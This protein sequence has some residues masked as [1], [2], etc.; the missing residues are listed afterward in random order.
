MNREFLE[1]LG[2]QK[3]QVDQIMAEHGK[4]VQTTQTKLTAS[5]DRVKALEGDLTAAN[6][7]VSDLK[8]ENKDTEAL[9]TKIKGYE[10]QIAAT[11][12][13]RVKERKQFAIKEALAKAGATD[14]DYLTFK[15]GDV[16]LDKTGN[17]KDLENRVKLLK[18]GNPTFFKVEEPPKDPKDQPKG[19]FQVIDTKLPNGKT[20]TLDVKTMSRE[21]INAN[22]EAIRANQQASK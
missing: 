5:E 14:V 6:K 20:V 17:I 13:E 15:L 9:Q 4:T 12:T 10:D 19:G 21:E 7:L 1:K 8:K 11:E 2:L 22:W 18:E 3:D 16:E